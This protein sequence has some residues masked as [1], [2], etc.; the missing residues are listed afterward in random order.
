[1]RRMLSTTQQLLEVFPKNTKIQASKVLDFL[2]DELKLTHDAVD[3][4]RAVLHTLESM[5]YC[6]YHI[7]FV[8]SD[9]VVFVRLPFL[10]VGNWIIW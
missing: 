6:K 5:G 4:A 10:R 7:N 1:M 2:I 9:Y 8:D 3:V